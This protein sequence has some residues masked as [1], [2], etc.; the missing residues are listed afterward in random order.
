LNG[1]PNV[2]IIQGKRGGPPLY[3]ARRGE[4]GKKGEGEGSNTLWSTS[5]ERGRMRGGRWLYTSVEEKKKFNK[6]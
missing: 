2:K 1:V 5:Q 4:G 3:N 6:S